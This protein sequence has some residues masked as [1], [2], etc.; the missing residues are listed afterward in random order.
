VYLNILPQLNFPY[1]KEEGER[2][3][4]EDC[5][6]PGWRSQFRTVKKKRRRS[7]VHTVRKG[8]AGLKGCIQGDD[9]SSALLRKG[10]ERWKPVTISSHTVKNDGKIWRYL[11]RVTITIPNF[12]KKDGKVWRD[13]SKVAITVPRCSKRYE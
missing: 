6:H 7:Q 4:E 5:R 8:W 12:K 1:D 11:F 9:H 13:V 10:R 3:G 2:S